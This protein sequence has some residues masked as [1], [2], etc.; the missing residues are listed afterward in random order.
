MIT[1][2]IV[3][4]KIHNDQQVAQV[5]GG[6]GLDWVAVDAKEMPEEL[7]REEKNKGGGGGV[8]VGGGGGGGGDAGGGAKV[9]KRVGSDDCDYTSKDVA[10]DQIMDSANHSHGH[11]ESPNVV[12]YKVRIKKTQVPH[13]TGKLKIV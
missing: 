10:K 11:K 13:V 9:R 2:I 1:F 4:T 8:G 3:K 12:Y 5:R 6:N 7:A